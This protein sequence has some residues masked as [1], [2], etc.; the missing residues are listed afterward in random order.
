[1]DGTNWNNVDLDLSANLGLSDLGYDQ[2]QLADRVLGPGERANFRF[3]VAGAGTTDRV[4]GD[5][6]TFFALDNIA[7][8]VNT[9]T[10]PEPTPMWAGYEIDDSGNVDTGAWLGVVNVDAAPW[11][12]SFSLEAWLYLPEDVIEESGSWSFVAN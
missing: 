3:Q 7:F 11:I 8:S 4:E 10:D 9:I 6:G 2:V 1:M 12:W 5:W